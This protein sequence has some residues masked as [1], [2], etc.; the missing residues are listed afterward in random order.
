MR[1]NNSIMLAEA[2][3]IKIDEMINGK[4]SGANAD[5]TNLVEI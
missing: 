5:S 1:Q 3:L 2:K 4:K